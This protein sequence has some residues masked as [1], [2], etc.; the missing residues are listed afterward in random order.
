[1]RAHAR[2]HMRSHAHAH[3]HEHTQTFLIHK[4]I[5]QFWKVEIRHGFL[6][7]ILPAVVRPSVES[8]LKGTGSSVMFVSPLTLLP[9]VFSGFCLGFRK[10]A[11]SCFCK[12]L[13][14]G[15]QSEDSKQDLHTAVV[16]Q[17]FNCVSR[18]R[19]ALCATFSRMACLLKIV[20]IL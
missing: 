10:N 3:T 1:M 15:N 16:A 18:E 9:S 8:H 20:L 5:V 13:I 2:A 12:P 4:K 14:Y 7:W 19:V 17:A 11:F 6:L